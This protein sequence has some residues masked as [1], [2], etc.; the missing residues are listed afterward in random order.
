MAGG[1]GDRGYRRRV[2][3]EERERLEL[4]V[5]H[6]RVQVAKHGIEAEI[7]HVAL[8]MARATAV[9]DDQAQVLT[10]PLVCVSEAGHSPLAEDIAQRHGRQPDQRRPVARQ[11]VR[12][13]DAVTGAG[14]SE[15]RLHALPS[16]TR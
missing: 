14:V 13:G 8:R 12:D 3:A 4:G 15:A 16:R 6:H 5:I 1:V 11:G 7:V 2:V 10:E 9:V